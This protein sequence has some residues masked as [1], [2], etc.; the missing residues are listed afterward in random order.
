VLAGFVVAELVREGPIWTSGAETNYIFRNTLFTMRDSL[1]AKR[2]QPIGFTRR[3][4]QRWQWG[5]QFP[6]P[7]DT[8]AD[9]EDE[10]SGEKDRVYRSSLLP[11]L[12]RIPSRT[13]CRHL[14]PKDPE[15]TRSSTI[16]LIR[17]WTGYAEPRYHLPSRYTIAPIQKPGSRLPFQVKIATHQSAI[18]IPHG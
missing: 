11:M 10:S 13:M 18:P 5:G 8:G 1:I 3:Y 17:L 6:D 9:P 12:R 2:I 14:R 7:P 15:N 4:G 16:I